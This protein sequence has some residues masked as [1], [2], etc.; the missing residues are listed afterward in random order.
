MADL[1]GGVVANKKHPSISNGH[2]VGE[3]EGLVTRVYLRILHNQVRRWRPPAHKLCN[4][5]IQEL[6]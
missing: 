6:K 2:G 1:N 4:N 5:Y 3:R